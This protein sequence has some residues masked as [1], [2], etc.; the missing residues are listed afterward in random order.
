MNKVAKLK[1]PDVN[2]KSLNNMNDKIIKVCIFLGGFLAGT[3]I[4]VNDSKRLYDYSNKRTFAGVGLAVFASSYLFKNTN[5]SNYLRVAGASLGVV[6]PIVITCVDY[7]KD[8]RLEFPS[9]PMQEIENSDWYKSV[10][11]NET[12]P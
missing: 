12:H 4:V 10:S 2:N 3:A 1:K 5:H 7:V 6:A 8:C 11:H 9:A